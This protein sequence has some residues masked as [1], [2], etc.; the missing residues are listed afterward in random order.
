M[1][2]NIVLL[3]IYRITEQLIFIAVFFAEVKRGGDPAHWSFSAYSECQ[4][5]QDKTA[6][7]PDKKH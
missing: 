3:I 5:G 7:G 1:I 4:E 2:E 6:W